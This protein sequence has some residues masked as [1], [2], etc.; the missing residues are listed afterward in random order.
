MAVRQD[1]QNSNTP[2]LGI[3]R[4]CA[5]DTGAVIDSIKMLIELQAFF[6]CSEAFACLA[7][8]HA[9]CLF[10]PLEGP[11]SGVLAARYWFWIRNQSPK[12]GNFHIVPHWIYLLG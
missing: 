12:R 2:R 8:R 10:V 9:K 1:P 5:G 11:C 3:A 7:L 4:A 6:C